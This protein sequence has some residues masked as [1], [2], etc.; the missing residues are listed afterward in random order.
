MV[1]VT[2]L[3]AVACAN[4]DMLDRLAN[5]VCDFD[6][7]CE[8][9]PHCIALSTQLVLN[10]QYSSSVSENSWKYF[11]LNVT[12][13]LDEMIVVVNI[14][15]QNPKLHDC[16]LFIRKGDIPDDYHWYLF[17]FIAILFISL[18][19]S[20]FFFLMPGITRISLRMPILPLLCR[21]CRLEFGSLDSGDSSRVTSISSSSM[22]RGP[23]VRVSYSVA[24]KMTT[25]ALPIVRSMEHARIAAF[26]TLDT[27]A[28]IANLVCVSFIHFRLATNL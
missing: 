19:L 20:L 12:A 5:L 2:A 21:T 22:S 8:D 6:W 4:K 9:F 24:L 14:T 13:P 3:L 11:S 1:R 18:S 10:R 15:N 27:M 26:A 28:P 23:L 7:Y 25:T 17:L 16:D